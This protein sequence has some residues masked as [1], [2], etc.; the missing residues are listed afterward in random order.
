M[1]KLA[2][3]K[4]AAELPELIHSAVTPVP[5]STALAAHIAVSSLTTAVRAS[6]VDL[7]RPP[8]LSLSNGDMAQVKP[9]PMTSK[10]QQAESMRRAQQAQIDLKQQQS[11]AKRQASMQPGQVSCRKD[12]LTSVHADSRTTHV[13][14]ERPAVHGR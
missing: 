9:G 6:S 5:P 11:Q 1:C 2:D 14:G 7:G 3:R 10:L 8:R 12:E 13:Y 4:P